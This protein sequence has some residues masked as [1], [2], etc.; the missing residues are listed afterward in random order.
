MTSANIFSPGMS[1]LRRWSAFAL[2]GSVL[3]GC[4]GGGG[5]STASNGSLRV[6]MTDAPSC[7]YDHVY[8]TVDRVR[9]SQSST[10]ADT[11]TGWTDIA[12]STPRRIDLLSLTNGVLEEL[13]TTALPAG[14]Y[15]QVRLVLVDNT[16]ASPLANAV[17]P[18][19]GA[20]VPL[21][22][23]SAQQS[24]LKL[25]A[26]FDVAAGQMADIVLDFDACKSIVKRGN[27]GQYNLKPVVSVFQRLVSSIEGYVTNSFVIGSTTVAAQVNGVTVRSTMP[28]V[29]GRFSI[30]YLATGTYNVVVTSDGRSTA[31]VT[32]VPVAAGLATALNGT[33]TAIATP[34]SAMRNVSGVLSTTSGSSTSLL[35]NARVRALQTLT[36]PVSVEIAN[37]TVDADLGSYS[38]RLPAAAPMKAAYVA[39]TAPALVADTAAAGKYTV[40]ASS[41]GYITQD[42]AVDVTTVD[43]TTSFGF[44]P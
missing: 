43:S 5:D 8:V 2:L 37:V 1:Q 32:G 35:A 36:G 38:L 23:P 44:A 34:V 10:A 19:G 16:T 29:T 31:V 17:Q 20:I 28:D 7:G 42:K 39:G 12:L 33:A 24:G 9:V 25:Q 41:T 22:T 40:Q 4:G 30:P 11:D 6:A 27:S 3:A 26:S 18:T 14:R 13:G 21:S 15:S